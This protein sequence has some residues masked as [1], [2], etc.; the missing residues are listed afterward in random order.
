V[1][2][3]PEVPDH[4]K[5]WF[6]HDKV[7]WMGRGGLPAAPP[8][9]PG[10]NARRAGET[11]L[12]DALSKVGSTAPRPGQKPVSAVPKPNMDRMMRM[13][14]E[15]AFMEKSMKRY[16]PR[17]GAPAPHAES[18]WFFRALVAPFYGMIPW[19]VKKKI[20]SVAS[21]VKGWKT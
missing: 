16:G 8:A 19:S 9:P 15:K 11:A 6:G 10:S 18:P 17:I 7:S 5:E 13:G 4:M 12:A 21:G 3:L 14:S 2:S 1:S 20:A